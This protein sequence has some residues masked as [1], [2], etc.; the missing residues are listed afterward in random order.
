MKKLIFMVAALSL[1]AGCGKKTAQ[2]VSHDEDTAKAIKIDHL[3]GTIG[4]G[5]AMHT[6]QLCIN[7]TSPDTVWVAITDSTNVRNANLL[8]GNAVEVAAIP[9]RDGSYIGLSIVGNQTYTEAVGRWTY[10]DPINAKNVVGVQIDIEG[11]ASSINM[12]T[13]VYDKWALTNTPSEIVLY[14]QSIGNGQTINFADTA[15]IVQNTDGKLQLAFKNG[16]FPFV[17]QLP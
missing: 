7:G 4:P 11:K 6:L 10:P 3:T 14:G 9:G 12:A 15:L 13:L 17:K 2:P 16:G 8:I 1:L 5:T